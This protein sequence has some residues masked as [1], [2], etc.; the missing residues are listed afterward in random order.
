MAVPP[1]WLIDILRCPETRQKLKAEPG[2][3]RRADGRWF[4]DR[5]GFTS[6]VFPAVLGGDDRRMNGVYERIAPF[7]DFSERVLGRLL[8]GVDTGASRA[9]MISLVELTPAMRFLEVSPGPGV[10]FPWLRD[11]LGPGSE[12][13]AVDLS[14]AMLRQCRARHSALGVELIHGNAQCLPFADESFDALFHFGGINL[15]NEPAR[16][17]DEFVRVVRVGGTV[18]WG[19]ERMSERFRHPLGRHLLPRL[20]PG[21]LRT[22]PSVPQALTDVRQH[23]VHRGLGY[24]VTARR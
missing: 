3:F 1:D 8:T 21:F 17:L 20:N 13:A 15:F 24:L 9:H 19:D 10:F 23:E 4:P 5:D 18:A 16:A 11:R 6:L 14:L 22:P 7:Y 12:F 2:G